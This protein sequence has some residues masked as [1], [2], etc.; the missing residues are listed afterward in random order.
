MVAVTNDYYVYALL[1]PRLPTASY[2]RLK[3]VPKYVGKGRGARAKVSA[4]L[5]AR[6]MD[7]PKSRW[8]RR[9]QREGL[10]PI[11]VFWK[12]GIAETEAF[13]IERRLIVKYGRKAVG[14]GPLL[15]RSNG[16]EG[17]NQFPKAEQVNYLRKLKD[18]GTKF[19]CV[20]ELHG[21]QAYVDHKCP[22]HGVVKTAPIH[23]LKRL[24]RNLPPCP[25]CGTEQRGPQMRKHRLATGEASYK[26]LF[27]K[28]VPM[29]YSIAGK[30]LGATVLTNH[31]CSTHGKFTITPANVR[32]K[33]TQGFRPCVQCNAAGLR[34]A[35]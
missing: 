18:S 21:H 6:Y 22:T 4:F 11:L 8:V 9:L 17:G 31:K 32:Q 15:N 20:A 16:G 7:S 25:K 23:V 29:G 35:L 33:L 1:D 34:G 30:Y 27:S 5:E 12:T 3:F 2:G 28:L 19:K 13:R 10:E 24:A 14:E 26:S